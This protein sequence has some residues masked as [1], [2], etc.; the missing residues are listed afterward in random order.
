[1]GMAGAGLF[2]PDQD[3]KQCEMP[4]NNLEEAVS[5]VRMR[6]FS[7]IKTALT[8]VVITWA[9]SGCVSL[10][11][12]E[13]E[14]PYRGSLYP[15]PVSWDGGPFQPELGDRVDF[16]VTLPTGW[17]RASFVHDALLL[18]RDGI[19]LQYMG[20]GVV[21]V[22][23]E[24]PLTKKAFANGMSPPDVATLELDEV[25]SNPTLRN[26]ALVDNT[27]FQVAGFPGFKL[28]YTFKTENGLRLERVHYGVM[29]RDW[30]YRVQYQAAARYY[31]DKDLATFE[32]VRES[33]RI[34]EK[35]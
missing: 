26:F 34:T 29:V 7:L 21:A 19:S 14:G 1:M 16:Q 20:I 24:L 5:G 13:V 35:P 3:P 31:F 28:V 25:R 6:S 30:V 22:G 10:P 18:T 9:L 27:P 33:F 32:Q 11:W 17:R 23:D 12:A 15:H 8:F 4:K 2:V